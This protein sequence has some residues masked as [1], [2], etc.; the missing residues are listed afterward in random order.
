MASRSELLTNGAGVGRCGQTD[1]DINPFLHQTHD[2]IRQHQVDFKV[3]IGELIGLLKT[4]EADPEQVFETLAATPVISPAAAMAGKAM[5]ADQA[6]PMFPIRLVA[7]DFGYMRGVADQLGA[8]VP[9]TA[10]GEA[11]FTGFRRRLG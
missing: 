5:L 6:A 11:V 4:S 1:G 2:P 9:M 7:K 3:W 8:E 10:T